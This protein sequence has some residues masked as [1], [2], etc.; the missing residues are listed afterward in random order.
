VLFTSFAGFSNDIYFQVA[1]LATIGLSTKNAILIVEFALAAQQKGETIVAAALEGA[2]LRLRPIVMTSLA[3][4]AGV[5]PLVFATGAGAISRQEIGVSIV[6]G[7][8][9]GTFLAV[10]YVPLFYVLVRSLFKPKQ[11]SLN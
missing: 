4:I 8:L 10:L 1:I 5:I 2:R 7:V 6:G 3:F 9:F 11:A